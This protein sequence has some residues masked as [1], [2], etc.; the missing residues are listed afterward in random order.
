M[1]GNIKADGTVTAAGNGGVCIPTAEKNAQF[2]KLKN[3][4]ENQTCFDCPNTRPTWASV[5]YGVFLC[6]DCSAAHRSMGVHLTFVRSVD[7]DEWTQSQIDAMRLGGNGNART[8]FRKHGFTDLYGSKLEK[9]YKSKAAQSYKAELAKLVDAEA[10]KRGEGSAAAINSEDSSDGGNSLLT[11]LDLL[12]K[13]NQEEEAKMKANGGGTLGS[14][15]LEPKVKLASSLAGA[16][17]LQVKP[18]GNLG[19]LRKPLGGESSSLLLRKKSSLSVS[20]K[21]KQRAT[22]LS[23]NNSIS[24]A[25]SSEVEE[26]TFE[27]IEETRKSVAVAQEKA[28]Q[29]SED[30]ALAK[31]LQEE[32]LINGSSFDSP[33]K[34]PTKQPVVTPAVSSVTVPLNTTSVPK[35]STK[36]E[37]L[38]KLKDMTSDFFSQM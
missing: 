36:D 20:S 18:T 3:V 19:T 8:Y 10:L 2:R 5:T 11:N 35:R 31:K 22:K 1:S 28:K 9:K 13:K 25:V 27:D 33:A 16:S 38:A 30:A 14:R 6:L 32:M 15:V 29:E 12:D 7:L 37:N 24:G 17:K 26:D 21:T 4:L 34:V 23:V